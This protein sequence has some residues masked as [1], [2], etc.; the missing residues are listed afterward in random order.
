[1]RG[2]LITIV[3]LLLGVAS[4]VAEMTGLGLVLFFAGAAI[5]ISLWLQAVQ[6]PR[7]ISARLLTRIDPHR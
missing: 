6:S 3:V 1:M 7:R 5:E 4:Y 2:H